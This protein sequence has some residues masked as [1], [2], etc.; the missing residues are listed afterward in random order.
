LA[1]NIL[2]PFLIS[3]VLILL[4]SFRA[5]SGV[6]DALKWSLILVAISILPVCSV[7]V[8]LA[9]KGKIDGVF[10]AVREQRT[11][12][13]LVATVWAVA[14]CVVLYYL[15]APPELLA[16]AVAGLSATVIF[17]CV[18]MWWKISLHTAFVA[19]LA[20]MLVFLYGWVALLVVVLVLFM[21]WVR[22]ELRRH[23]LAQVVVGAILA[24]LVVSVVFYIFLPWYESVYFVG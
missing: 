23:S 18:N 19:A 17:M 9:R 13:Y 3:V 20:T 15:K 4:L 2:N 8:Y 10:T 6:L 16:A 7:I 22:V 12:I 21:F 5:T 1:S 11:R 14:D 24:A